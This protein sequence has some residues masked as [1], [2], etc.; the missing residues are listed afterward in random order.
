M[1]EYII[2]KYAIFRNY[3]LI[4]FKKFVIILRVWITKRLNIHAFILFSSLVFN[5]HTLCNCRTIED[6]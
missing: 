6:L 3:L 1:I 4:F 2:I 5:I